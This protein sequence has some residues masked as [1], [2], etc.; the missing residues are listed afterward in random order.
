[1]MRCCF[2][3]T[4]KSSANVLLK[5]KTQQINII[6]SDST[7]NNDGGLS[8]KNNSPLQR[9]SKLTSFPK[10][11]TSC[12]FKRDLSLN[13]P[14]LYSK[15][16]I[17][18]DKSNKTT[19][20]SSHQNRQY[21]SKNEFSVSANIHN[22]KIN[23]E[24]SIEKIEEDM[25]N[26]MSKEVEIL[27]NN[28]SLKDFEKI[29]EL[30]IQNGFTIIE[31]QDVVVLS[32]TINGRRIEISWDP[33]DYSEL[34]EPPSKTFEKEVPVEK[35]ELLS[36]DQLKEINELREHNEESYNELRDDLNFRETEENLDNSTFFQDE[37]NEIE[38]PGQS[39]IPVDVKIINGD[40]SIL[41]A[42]CSA[43]DEGLM[44]IYNVGVQN[45]VDESET[46]FVDVELL[47]ESLQHRLYDYI[48]ELGGGDATAQFIQHYNR[49][50]HTIKNIDALSNIINDFL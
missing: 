43:A 18:E 11:T 35:E 10:N 2:N 40:S 25:N 50:Q 6:K 16:N 22:E 48:E 5:G 39:D 19:F 28:E 17:K 24:E 8:F 33:E 29:K 15:Y 31:K 32:R 41:W 34:E 21:I 38:G 49:N 30:L 20:I 23:V 9:V 44:Y 37:D 26:L 14:S 42:K 36:Q 1:M 4:S 47:S 46:K 13:L 27:Q 7:H 3:I 12:F 45:V